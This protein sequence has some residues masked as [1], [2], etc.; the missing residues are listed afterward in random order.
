MQTFS[1]FY[2]IIHSTPKLFTKKYPYPPELHSTSISM[3]VTHSMKGSICDHC[4]N[5]FEK[6]ALDT[7]TNSEH[8]GQP[9]QCHKWYDWVLLRPGLGHIEMNISKAVF[10][11]MWVPVMRHVANIM[12]FKSPRAMSYIQG[13][14]DNHLTWQLVRIVLESLVKELMVPYVRQS[15]EAG[16]EVTVQDYMQWMD[17]TKNKNY[18]LHQKFVNVLIAMTQMRTGIRT[19]SCRSMLAGRQ[20]LAPLMFIGRNRIHQRLLL[21]DMISRQQQPPAVKQFV[22]RTTTYSVSGE[23]TRHEGGDFILEAKNKLVKSWIPPGVLSFDQWVHATR[24]AEQ[25]EGVKKEVLARHGVS[26][27]STATVLSH[28][29]SV[30]HLRAEV[31]RQGIIAAPDKEAKYLLSLDGEVLHPSVLNFDVSASNNYNMSKQE[32]T[33]GTSLTREKVFITLEEA[34]KEKLTKAELQEHIS[35][36]IQA[37]PEAE[38]RE[39]WERQLSKAKTKPELLSLY[40]DIEELG[41]ECDEDHDEEQ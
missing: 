23:N 26:S 6:D 30:E 13:C 17:H 12:G 16:K 31:R 32:M 20:R 41:A 5:T 33:G 3:R 14:G 21:R 24:C 22:E 8:K 38:Q 1:Y 9:I 15:M 19:N 29:A 35:S 2:P 4:G 34:S 36:R 25:L 27:S 40:S 37:I 11:L 10:K 28:Q 7:H 18:Q 39:T